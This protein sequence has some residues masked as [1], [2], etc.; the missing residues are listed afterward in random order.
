MPYKDTHIDQAKAAVDSKL[1]LRS[2][3]DFLKRLYGM[4]MAACSA[5]Q[6]LLL[7]KF[8]LYSWNN[9]SGA[10]NVLTELQL[11]KIIREINA[12]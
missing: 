10:T 8:A 11:T 9:T 5:T 6:K 7:L 1:A 2:Y 3:S 12:L 4:S